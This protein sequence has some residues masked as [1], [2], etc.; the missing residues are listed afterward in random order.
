M[1]GDDRDVSDRGVTS[2]DVRRRALGSYGRGGADNLADG[3]LLELLTDAGVVSAGVE[4]GR[5]GLPHGNTTEVGEV[6][7]VQDLLNELVGAGLSTAKTKEELGVLVLVLGA[8][9]V[10]LPD[11]VVDDIPGIG[12]G[13]GGAR[14]IAVELEEDGIEETRVQSLRLSDMLVR[15]GTLGRG[16]KEDGLAGGSTE[17]RGR[18]G[19]DLLV[20]CKGVSV[21]RTLTSFLFPHVLA[22][23]YRESCRWSGQNR[24]R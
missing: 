4:V 1:A 21:K 13:D 20:L 9:E 7:V 10:V 17:P 24:R 3:S 16:G 8:G 23:P 15:G 22:L 2:E 11:L 6:L 12:T 19:N 14:S 5:V 18:V